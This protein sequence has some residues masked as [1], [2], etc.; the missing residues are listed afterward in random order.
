MK[1]ILACQEGI[2]TLN[3]LRQHK[4]KNWQRM[5]AIVDAAHNVDAYL[6]MKILIKQKNWG[7][8]LEINDSRVRFKI[9]EK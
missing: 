9:F 5:Y 3:F 6:Q 2:H 8:R 7:A 4:H 1:H